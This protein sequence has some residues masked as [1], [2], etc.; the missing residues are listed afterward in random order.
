MHRPEAFG[1]IVVTLLDGF[2]PDQI[3]YTK[4]KPSSVAVY[5]TIAF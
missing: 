3:D 4:V 5:D 1:K 2:S